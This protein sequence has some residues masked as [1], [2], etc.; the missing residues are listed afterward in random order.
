LAERL[1]R[2]LEAG[3][4]AGGEHGPVHS[5][6]LLVAHEQAWSIVNLRVDWADDAPISKLR[7]LWRAYEPQMQDY[8]TRALDPPALDRA[9]A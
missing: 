3:L 4:A 8:L 5:A 6:G 7:A 9:K 1:L 2:A